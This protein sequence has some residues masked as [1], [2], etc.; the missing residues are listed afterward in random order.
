MTLGY[1]EWSHRRQ[2][3]RPGFLRGPILWKGLVERVGR[4]ADEV[5]GLIQQRHGIPDVDL[6]SERPW[7]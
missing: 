3:I 6:S 1:R 2:P 4:L 5:T 7:A